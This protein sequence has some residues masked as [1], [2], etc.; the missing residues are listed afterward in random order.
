MNP[1]SSTSLSRRFVIYIVLFSA[2]FTLIFSSLQ[3]YTHYNNDLIWI[4][5]A[6]EMFCISLFFLYV[7][8]RLIAK[9]LHQIV[10]YAQNLTL[11]KLDEPL[12]LSK[13]N[14]NDELDQVVAA[15]NKMRISL[16]G[17]KQK[18]DEHQHRQ[19]QILELM[20]VAVFV[21]DANGI[22]TYVNQRAKEILGDEISQTSIF[23]EFP[24]RYHV[25]DSPKKQVIAQALAGHKIYLDD[26]EIQTPTKRMQL[27]AW[28]SPIFNQRYEVIAAIAVFQDITARKLVEENRIRLAQAEEAEKV[29]MRLSITDESTQLYNRRHFN[30]EFPK[31]IQRAI[32]TQQMISFL[33]LDIDYFKLYN[34]NYGHLKGDEVLR[35][36]GQIL[37]AQCQRAGDIPLRLGGEEFG[38]I[39]SGLT[40]EQAFDF[41]NC[42]RI[43]IQDANIEHNFSHVRPYITASFGLVTLTANMQ[44]TQV[45]LYKQADEALYQ[46]KHLGRNQVIQVCV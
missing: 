38:V 37:K 42:I 17:D 44:L 9:H 33:M 46:A 43:A 45:A 16:M 29:A 19:Q 4:G 18:L 13:P 10:R 5:K 36:I 30:V 40:A 27:E 31:E 12:I 28:G 35:E 34:D 8:H 32:R 14:K 22:P 11:D 41:A 15:I 6:I 26:M 21:T 1:K 20:P 2:L 39:F 25:N 7:F 23:S 3:F 24:K